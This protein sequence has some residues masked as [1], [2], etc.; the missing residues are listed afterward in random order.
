MDQTNHDIIPTK[1]NPTQNISSTSPTQ[2]SLSEKKWSWKL[3]VIIF[4]IIAIIGWGYFFL[5]DR[6]NFSFITNTINPPYQSLWKI[7]SDQ[8]SQYSDWDDFWD[9]E[10]SKDWDQTAR[11]NGVWVENYIYNN[12]SKKHGVI[13]FSGFNVWSSYFTTD[14]VEFMLSPSEIVQINHDRFNY[15]IIW[16]ENLTLKKVSS[17]NSFINLEKKDYFLWNTWNIYTLFEEYSVDDTVYQS[18][19]IDNKDFWDTKWILLIKNHY[20]WISLLAQFQPFINIELNIKNDQ[21][22]DRNFIDKED[23]TNIGKLTEE[24]LDKKYNPE[25]KYPIEKFIGTWEDIQISQLKENTIYEYTNTEFEMINI[26]NDLN[27]DLLFQVKYNNKE[28]AY[29]KIPLLSHQ[30]QEISTRDE[31]ISFFFKKVTVEEILKSIEPEDDPWMITIQIGSPI[32]YLSGEDN[33]SIDFKELRDNFYIYNDTN[34]DK[35]IRINNKPS[36][37]VKKWTIIWGDIRR[38]FPHIHL[39]LNNKE[40]SISNTLSTYK[41]NVIYT[42]NNSI[43]QDWV[44]IID[45]P[46]SYH[47][48]GITLLNDWDV[49]YMLY[50]DGK[51]SILSPW[52]S[53]NIGTSIIMSNYKPNSYHYFFFQKA[54]TPLLLSYLNDYDLI[55]L[56]W[57]EKY[58][59]FDVNYKK[60][61]YNNT[62]SDLTLVIDS[63]I[64]YTQTTYTVKAWEIIKISESFPEHFLIKDVVSETEKNSEDT[65]HEDGVYPSLLLHNTV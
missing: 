28:I 11:I 18:L 22:I 51:I 36:L 46:Q 3:I 34:E 48:Y 7:T 26:H 58:K 32:K 33:L 44:S 56:N 52:E 62:D 61:F 21:I 24:E 59:Q 29:N 13:L 63:K 49:P 54:D 37:T 43:I 19:L 6:I 15:K 8:L 38:F 31:T 39:T 14:A 25:K 60:Y 17:W 20:W 57:V 65:H 50:A 35:I 41:E 4:L 45:D 16:D 30:I 64:A 53:E 2:G 42:F 9:M 47:A 1:L 27:D 40:S 12:S 55:T 23:W 5:K 10:I